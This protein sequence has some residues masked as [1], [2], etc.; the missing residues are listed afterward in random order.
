MKFIR[1]RHIA[2]FSLL[3]GCS[4]LFAQTP[5]NNPGGNMPSAAPGDRPV[6]SSGNSPAPEPGKFPPPPPPPKDS[7]NIIKYRGNR[8][9][10]ENLPLKI[11]QTKCI[12][13]ENEMACIEICFNQSIN[14]RSVKPFSILINNTP[15]PAYTKVL[16]SKKGDSFKVFCPVNTETFKLKV[17]KIKSFD[18]SEIEPVELLIKVEKL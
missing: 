8:T 18:D 2:V 10:T 1:R 16:F 17:Q 15:L 12:I 14:P 11:I 4:V 3:M 5:G 6:P 7:D 9:Y 13:K